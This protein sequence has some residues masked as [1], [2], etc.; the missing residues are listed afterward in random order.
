MYKFEKLE[1]WDL[2]LEYIDLCYQV[3]G[4]LPNS[5]EFNL[6]GQLRR[7]ATSVALNIAEGSTG[8]SD[9]EQ[10]RFL[11]MALRSLIESVACMRI[12]SRRSYKVDG[13]K[14]DTAYR[15]SET[16]ARKIQAM[17]RVL[18]RDG[19]TVKELE[20]EYSPG[21]GLLTVAEE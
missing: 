21:S 13:D 10:V 17:R 3:A 1:I 7:A 18:T 12:I 16:L 11:G 5:E 14:L 19:R 4:M 15:K 6:K 8:Q 20:G 9:A 2:A